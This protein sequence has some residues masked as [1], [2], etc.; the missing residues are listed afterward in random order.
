MNE[1][2]WMIAL[3]VCA[4]L[5]ASA[6]TALLVPLRQRYSRINP[7]Y[8]R[9]VKV[10]FPSFLFAGIGSR[11]D[12][13][14]VRKYGVIA[15]MFALHILGYV[16]TLALWFVVPLLYQYGV[17]LSELWAAPVAFALFHTIVVVIAEAACMSKSNHASAADQESADDNEGK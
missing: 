12:T 13:G 11:K 16:L 10:K 6:S 2:P 7:K 1:N 15:P 8:F 3:V 17:D 14:N 5:L 9:K 4:T